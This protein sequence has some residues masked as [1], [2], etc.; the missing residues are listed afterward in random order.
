MDMRRKKGYS[1]TEVIVSMALIVLVSVTAFM[2][3]YVGINAENNSDTNMQI[4]SSAET[5]RK[6]FEHTLR[7]FGKGENEEEK[8]AF[9]E[10][11]NDAVSFSFGADISEPFANE[12]LLGGEWKISAPADTG[13]ATTARRKRPQRLLL[14]RGP[15]G[16][17]VRLRIRGVRRSL[18]RAVQDK[19][20]LECVLRHDRGLSRR[21]RKGGVSLYGAILK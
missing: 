5:F 3:C 15:R 16:R 6:C 19:S 4:F 8:D 13:S 18:A 20:A 11:F 14:R 2:V 10:G 21:F 1:L 7:Q 12:T 17:H 9:L